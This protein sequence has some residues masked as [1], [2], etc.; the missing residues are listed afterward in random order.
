[1]ITQSAEH[2]SHSKALRPQQSTEAAA[3]HSDQQSAHVTGSSESDQ[4]RTPGLHTECNVAMTRSND[5]CVWAW[6]AGGR[7]HETRK[8]A[9]RGAWRHG[10]T[11]KHSTSMEQKALK[12][13]WMLG[14]K[15]DTAGYGK[16]MRR[17]GP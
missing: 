4:G 3:E 14:V 2:L 1:M 6:L 15:D 5:A 10:H 16:T 17:H 12:D 8:G 13:A 11:G 7:V 9:M